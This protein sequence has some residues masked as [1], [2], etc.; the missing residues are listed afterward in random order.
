MNG[1][2]WKKLIG[3]AVPA[4]PSFSAAHGENFAPYMLQILLC[5]FA[6]V[7]ATD[8]AAPVCNCVRNW[9]YDVPVVAPNAAAK[10]GSAAC[11]G[12]PLFWNVFPRPAA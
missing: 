4:P 11:P 2:T 9:L 8:P 3:Y 10:I 1:F 6:S 12:S 7:P 5:V